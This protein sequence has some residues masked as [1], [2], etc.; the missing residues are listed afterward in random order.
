MK[1]YRLACAFA[2]LSMPTAALADVQTAAFTSAADR[3]VTQTSMF[4]GTTVSIRLSGKASEP[5][6]RAGLGFGG[7]ARNHSTS[8]LRIGQGLELALAGK[9]KPALMLAGTDAGDLGKAAKLSGGGKTALIIGGV[10]VLALG[11]G[12]LVLADE[13]EESRNSD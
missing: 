8:E 6:Y 5:R 10:V 1:T 11:V 7:M 9:K 13:I 12:A 3:P 4:V 2:L